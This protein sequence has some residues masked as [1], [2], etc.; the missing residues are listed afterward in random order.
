VRWA[1]LLVFG[2][3]AV[4]VAMYWT[5]EDM[6]GQ[7]LAER[8]HG[9]YLPILDRGD[10]HMLYLMARSTALDLDWRFDNDL[11]RFGDVWGEPITETGR[12]GIV[13]PIGP[14]LVW[15][16]MIWL[17]ELGAVLAN[18]F[19]ADIPLHGYTLWHQR[20][21]FLSSA[22]FACSAVWL[23]RRVALRCGL[24]TWSSAYAAI[25]ILLGTS[26]TYY[27]TYMPSYSHAMDAGACAA[28]LAYWAATI[29]RR[30]LRRWLALGTLL[31]LATLVRTQ[32]LALG[33]VIGVEAIEA[34]VRDLRAHAVDWRMRAILL[35]G[36]GLVALATTI[37]VFTPQLLEW[38][39]VFGHWTQLPQ[40]AHYTRPGSPMLLELLFSPRNGWFSTTPLAYL[41]AIGL[42]CLPRSARVVALGMIAASI[43]ETYL[44]STI[45][46]WW[47]S[48]SFG[49]RRMCNVSLPLVVGLAALLWRLGRLAARVP[50]VPRTAWHALAAIVLAV[51]IAWNLWRVRDLRAGRGA[52]EELVPTCCERVPRLLRPSAQW[53]YERIGNPFELPASA[54]YAL[55]HGVSLRR[56]DLS[57]GNYPVIPPF[58]AYRSDTIRGTRGGWNIGAPGAEPYLLAGW[59]PSFNAARPARYTTA[60]RATAIVPNLVP[61]TQRY[62][63]W[64]APAG[65]LEVTVRWDGDV[66]AN[67]VL[68]AGWNEVTF[69]L[70]EVGV[71]QHE[72]SIDAEPRP[73]VLREGWRPVDY[74]VGVAVGSLDIELLGP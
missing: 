74:A 52:P 15:T 14:A 9:Q 8:G 49:Q 68:T 67:R 11:A 61:Y 25:A 30:D 71:G 43:V 24:G 40:G 42:C 45:A 63:L 10:G 73:L 35:V 26:L 50:R 64:L 66:V 60:A 29:G 69:V 38:R 23:G 21:V 32:E 48:A 55:R 27:A 53:I 28:F 58:G 20:L 34:T 57:V 31:G 18:S 70:D 16:P 13:Q 2:A 17:A 56:W 72:L 37:L 39:I 62:T 44:A 33:I 22:L 36:G 6:A 7:P 5:N 4:V 51:P 12:K 41:G 47:G 65:S 59:S 3:C 19:G 54:W 46:D 1:R